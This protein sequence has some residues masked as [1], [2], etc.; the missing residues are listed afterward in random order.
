MIWLRI[1]ALPDRGQ[2]RQQQA[3]QADA[4]KRTG[5]PGRQQ[6][7]HE[8]Q[9]EQQMPTPDLTEKGIAQHQA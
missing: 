5:T 6:Q 4:P 3:G 2:R 9:I 1:S 7:G 8:Q